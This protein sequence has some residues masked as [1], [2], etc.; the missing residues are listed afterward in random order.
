MLRCIAVVARS[1]VYLHLPC[2]RH[3]TPTNKFW[4]R[5]TAKYIPSRIFE[6][7]EV[8]EE[9]EKLTSKNCTN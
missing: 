6:P 2:R 7:I 5:K 1:Q 4:I 9:E 3:V 8:K